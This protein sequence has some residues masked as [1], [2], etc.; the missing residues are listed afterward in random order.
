MRSP[1][2]PLAR[3][4][5]HLRSHLAL[6]VLVVGLGA[7][8]LGAAYVGALELAQRWLWPEHHSLAAQALILVGAGALVA[9]GTRALGPSGDVELLVDNIHV[10]GGAETTRE[11]RAVVPLSLVCVASGGALGPEAPLVQTA[12]TYGT[13]VARWRR[14]TT[15]EVRIL[16]ITG[17]AAGFTVLFGAPLGAAIFALEVLHRRG[18]QHH[19]ALLPALVG[20]LSGYGVFTVLTQ[21]GLQPVWSFPSPTALVPTDLAWAAVAGAVGAAIAAAFTVGV[22]LAR[23]AVAPLPPLVVPVLGG[24]VLAL[25]GWWSPYALTFGEGQLGDLV[26]GRLAAA[27]IAVAVVAK[28]AGTTVTLAARWKG[29]FIIPLLFCGAGIGQLIHLWVPSTSAAVVTAGVMIALVTGVTNTPVGSTLV[30]TEMAGLVLLPTGVLSAVVALVL[31]RRVTLIE[32][33]RARAAL[34]PD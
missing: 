17:M 7:G 15:T 30:V 16:T 29:G 12:G 25:L 1:D 20:S 21:L 31:T 28:L 32:S 3:A 26:D 19:E 11:L 18:L 27:G 4:T 9:V 5:L 14:L 6:P 10:L 24:V 34:T 13:A 22:R 23:R 2:S 8:L 33:Q